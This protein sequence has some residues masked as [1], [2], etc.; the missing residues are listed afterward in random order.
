MTDKQLA[1]RWWGNARRLRRIV[2]NLNTPGTRADMRLYAKWYAQARG[3]KV[4]P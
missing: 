4:T 2:S 1:R 3:W